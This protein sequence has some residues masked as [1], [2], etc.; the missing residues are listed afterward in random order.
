MKKIFICICFLLV[1]GCASNERLFEIEPAKIIQR[2]QPVYP[3]EAKELGLEGFVKVQ[4]T[5]TAEGN[6]INPVV[7]ESE[8]KIVFDFAAMDAAK[9]IKYQPRIVDGQPQAIKGVVYRFFFEL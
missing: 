7:L 3:V 6:V 1:T 2:V 8:P 5:V 9:K 4:Y